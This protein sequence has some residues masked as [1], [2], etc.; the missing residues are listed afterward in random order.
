MGLQKNNRQDY[1]RLQKN[2]RWDNTPRLLKFLVITKIVHIGITVG[3]H[4]CIYDYFGATMRFQIYIHRDYKNYLFFDEKEP[5][6]DDLPRIKT[7]HCFALFNFMNKIS[8]FDHLP[9]IKNVTF[10]ENCRCRIMGF[11]SN[12]V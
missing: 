8:C 6:R 9:R 7:L 5:K 2:Y 11:C 4:L 10:C 1:V 12:S 3:L